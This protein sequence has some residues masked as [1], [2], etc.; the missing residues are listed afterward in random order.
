MLR[1]TLHLHRPP[2]R[3]LSLERSKHQQRL[4]LLHL[5]PES[6]KA[7]RRNRIRRCRSEVGL[8]WIRQTPYPCTAVR[9]ARLRPEA[10][11]SACAF[12]ARSRRPTRQLKRRSVEG[13]SYPLVGKPGPRLGRR[14]RWFLIDRPLGKESETQLFRYQAWSAPCSTSWF[15][16]LFQPSQPSP[17]L[18]SLLTR[19]PWICRMAERR[20]MRVEGL[21]AMKP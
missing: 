7:Q 21:N 6:R 18:I 3:G 20:P 10:D 11:I 14:T 16:N 5:R 4:N 2:L 8:A 15:L 19:R 12:S 9:N 17:R 13:I 1:R